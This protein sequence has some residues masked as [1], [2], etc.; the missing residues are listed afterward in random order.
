MADW[1]PAELYADLGMV[2]EIAATLGVKEKR[3]MMWIYRREF[4]NCPRPVT[5]LRVGSIYSLAEWKGWWALWK[6]TRPPEVMYVGR[7]LALR[8]P[9]AEEA[10]EEA[11]GEPEESTED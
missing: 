1:T 8:E 11:D 7:N 9:P 4:T 5:R 10:A 3:V 2:P 6:V